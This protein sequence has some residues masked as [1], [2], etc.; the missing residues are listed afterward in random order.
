MYNHGLIIWKFMPFHLW[1]LNLIHFGKQYCKNLTILVCSNKSEPIPW[2]IRFQ[3]VYETFINDANINI[4]HFENTL[5]A[6]SESSREISKIR[7]IS[8]KEMFPDVD[9]FFSSEKYWDYVWEFINIDHKLYDINRNIENIS[10][11]QIREKPMLYRD[12]LTPIAKPYFV[13]KICISGTESTWKSTLTKIL[14]KHYNTTYVPEMAR[15]LV[16]HTENVTINDLNNIAILQ[17][18]TCLEKQIDANKIIFCDTWL[19]ITKSYCRFLFSKE[20]Q[21]DSRVENANIFDLHLFLESNCEYIQDWTRLSIAERNRLNTFHYNQ[22]QQYNPKIV[23]RYSWQ[24]RIHEA[25][26]IIDNFINTYT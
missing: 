5:P 4:I 14:A 26:D 16:K 10:G 7:S 2:I 15:Y 11:T 21:V 8:L 1:H 24:D 20:L 12:F 19:D 3:W 9:V 17:A 13:K 25:I 22:I 6:T 23:T 18:A